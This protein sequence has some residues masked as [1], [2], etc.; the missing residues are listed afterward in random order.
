MADTSGND[1]DN[2]DDDWSWVDDEFSSADMVVLKHER[3]EALGAEEIEQE[4]TKPLSAL[5][6]EYLFLQSLTDD[7]EDDLTSVK[8]ASD[9]RE[10][11]MEPY[12]RLRKALD[13]ASSLLEAD[14]HERLA[15]A[16]ER[17]LEYVRYALDKHR[18]WMGRAL[19]RRSRE[20]Q[21]DARERERDAETRAYRNT[22]AFRSRS[23][24]PSGVRQLE[25]DLQRVRNPSYRVPRGQD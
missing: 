4:H 25:K 13:A 5:E 16:I 6:V 21:R 7:L 1:A 9:A 12:P 20:Q 8:A 2:Q 22:V 19:D 23:Y 15:N 14:P 11:G 17:E 3:L 18:E 24:T 10:L